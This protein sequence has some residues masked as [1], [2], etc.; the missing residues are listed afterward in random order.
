MST[1]TEDRIKWL[2]TGTIPLV[3]IHPGR[4]YTVMVGRQVKHVYV[5]WLADQKRTMPCLLGRCTLCGESNPRRP[6]SYFQGM[7][8]RSDGG[9]FDWRA[10]VIEVPYQCGKI[11]EEMPGKP[12]ALRRDRKCGPVNIGTFLFPAPV[13][14]QIDFVLQ[15]RLL[16]FWRLPAGAHPCVVGNLGPQAD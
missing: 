7:H 13:P 9:V 4:P 11:L 15:D 12:V 14:K 10:A 8:Y 16:A 1:S 6:L 5:H 3:R 2:P